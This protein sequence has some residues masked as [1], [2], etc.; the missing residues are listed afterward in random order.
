VGVP[1]GRQGSPRR[2]VLPEGWLDDQRC[3]FL[4]AD[5]ELEVSGG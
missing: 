5:A 2:V 3:D 1:R 4:D